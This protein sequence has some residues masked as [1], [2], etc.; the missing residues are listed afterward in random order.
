MLIIDFNQ[1]I[2][3]SL[4]TQLKSTKNAEL[5]DNLVRHIVLSSILHLRKKFKE[6]DNIVLAAD[7]KNYWRKDLFPY[8]KAHRK[9]WREESD[10]DWNLIFN[11][12]NSI[13]D[14][15][16]DYFPYKVIKIKSAEADDIIA[17]LSMHFAEQG[18]DVMVVSADKDF[19]QLQVNQHIKQYS[20][21]LKKF[22]SHSNPG[23]YLKLHIME[24]DRGDGIP[25]F[26]SP[27][28]V[29]VQG[30]RQKRLLSTKKELWLKSKPEDFCD[31]V[32]L[33]NWRRN[34]QLIDL[35][36]IPQHIKDQILQAYEEYSV[37][38]KRNLFPYFV[39]NRLTLL[40]EEIHEF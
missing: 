7:D 9:K 39:Q 33:R 17:T 2:I 38:E 36:K 12:L 22:L 40:L 13:R 15:I 24:G 28:D 16:R 11:T 10:Y 29:F 18:Q 21:F 30:N 31:E 35:T 19:I 1:T 6:Y 27:D 23:E 5:N 3:A 14:E 32:M 20:P 37:P 8:Y 34:E 25:N 4:M 26:L